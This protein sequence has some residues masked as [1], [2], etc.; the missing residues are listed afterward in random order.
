MHRPNLL[1]LLFPGLRRAVPAAAGL[2]LLVAVVPAGRASA[3]SGGCT[4]SGNQVTC[5]FTF[6]QSPQ[7]WTVPAGVSQ[8]T[9]T[10]YGA[11]GGMS[12]TGVTGGLGAA[13]TATLPVTAGTVL[14]LNLGQAGGTSSGATIGGGGAAGPAAGGGGGATDVRTPAA[15]GTY[16]L[17]NRL[18][19]AGGGGGA[20]AADRRAGN[21][22]GGGGGNA[23]SPGGTGQSADDAGATLGGGGGGRAGTTAGSGLGGDGGTAGTSTSSCSFT[24]AGS[25]GADGGT[26]ASQGTGGTGSQNSGTGGGGGGASYTGGVSGAVITDGVAAPDNAPN[27]EAVITYTVPVTAT[28]TTTALSSSANPSVAGQPVTFTA[29]VSPD[30]PGSWLTPTGTVTFSDGGSPIGTATLDASGT[31]TIT[32]WSLAAGAHTITASYGGDNNF[33][34]STGSLTQTVNPAATATTTALSSSANPSVAGQ[35]VTFTA[36]V[37]PNPPGAGTPTGTVTFSDGGSPIGTATLDASGTATIT[38]SSLTAGAHT[39]TA[40]YGGDNNFS[41]STGTATVKVTYAFSGYL[42]PVNNPPTVNTGKAGKTY[43]VKW[44]LQDAN[45]NYISALSAVKSL[46]YKPTACSAFSTDP[47]DALATTTTGAT[48]LRYDATA[49]QYIYNWA[50]PGQGCYTLFLTL[51]SGQVLPAYFKLS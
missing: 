4:T 37:S 50:T 43:P 17:A 51:D 33:S 16:P 13:V 42:A 34:A 39:I 31:A 6:P 48:S 25:P 44:Q 1:T 38:T 41:A 7:T 22:S 27:G 45:G 12:S 23:D 32:P 30:P 47:T 11:E 14:Q 26:G 28:A 9:F 46:T 40:S 35:P 8:A 18:L 49:N 24:A 21:G 10:L 15:D 19:V 29:T 2:A 20:G 5:T 3:A 36:T